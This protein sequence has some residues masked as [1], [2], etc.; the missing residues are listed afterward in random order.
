MTILIVFTGYLPELMYPRIYERPDTRLQAAEWL[1]EVAPAEATICHKP[2]I[3]FAVPPIGMGGSAYGATTAKHYQG[4]L[5]NWGLLYYASDYFRNNQT[6]PVVN[7]L[8][9][10]NLTTQEQQAKQIEKWLRECDWVILSDRFADQYMPL[11]EDFNAISNF[12]TVM[13]SNQN[14]DWYQTVEFRSLPGFLGIT[15]DDRWSELTFRSFDHPSTW[16]FRRR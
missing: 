2:D 5:L 13:L 1:G 14:P 8:D 7:N 12:Y 11:P 6:T 9:I 15:I 10:E 4:F 3:G 16:I